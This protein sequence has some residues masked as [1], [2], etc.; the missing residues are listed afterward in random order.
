M[1]YYKADKHF[2]NGDIYSLS[3]D[4]KRPRNQRVMW[5]YGWEPLMV[6]HHHVKFGVHRHCGSRDTMF[7]VIKDED[8]RCS[9]FNLPLLFISERHGLKAQVKSYNNSNPGHT[10]LKQKS[11]KNLKIKTVLGNNSARK[12]EKNGNC[13][14]F[15]VTRK[16][17]NN[18]KAIKVK[19]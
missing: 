7:L 9:C 8:S 1:A 3:C 19:Q 13:K 18:I 2:G 14:T 17:K 11:E 15:C 16:F 4:F 12:E 10:S 5:L 6:I